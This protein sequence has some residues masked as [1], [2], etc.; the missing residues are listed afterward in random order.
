[1]PRMLK[2]K[3]HFVCLAGLALVAL[4]IWVTCGV[5]TTAKSAVPTSPLSP[6]ATQSVSLK[7]RTLLIK[8]STKVPQITVDEYGYTHLGDLMV[9]ETTGPCAKPRDREEPAW[10]HVEDVEPLQWEAEGILRYCLKNGK[11]IK[12]LGGAG[13]YACRIGPV[14]SLGDRF[15]F[16][17]I[18][19]NGRGNWDNVVAFFDITGRTYNTTDSQKEK[20]GYLV[21]LPSGDQV[22][23][24]VLD[25][26]YPTIVRYDK[27]GNVCQGAASEVI[28]NMAW[29]C[30]SF[31][32]RMAI[33]FR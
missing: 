15:H 2:G 29:L 11:A 30:H 32:P 20:I 12:D 1:M 7:P 10:E 25:R 33:M 18:L 31:S 28:M 5:D 9:K 16:A 17:G 21:K 8:D 24:F 19:G 27:T 22:A 3:I 4:V 14:F 23:A 6:S 26:G 13:P